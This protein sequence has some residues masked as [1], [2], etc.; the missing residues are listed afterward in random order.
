[1]ISSQN[2]KIQSSSNI[3]IYIY[4]YIKKLLNY[5]EAV[6]FFVFDKASG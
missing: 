3:Y 4:I 1:M 6:L 2:T 5:P